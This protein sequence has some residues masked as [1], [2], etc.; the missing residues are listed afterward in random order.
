MD[1]G[2]KLV[3]I[4]ADQVPTVFQESIRQVLQPELQELEISKVL[5]MLRVPGLKKR[6]K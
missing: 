2:S 3:E 5:E 1:T 4:T 6:K